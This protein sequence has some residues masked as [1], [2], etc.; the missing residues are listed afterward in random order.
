M[1]QT[2]LR[3]TRYGLVG[4][5][6]SNVRTYVPT[7]ASTRSASVGSGASSVGCAHSVA[8]GSV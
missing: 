3:V 4:S 2:F 1:A 6:M 8:G 7:V 5:S